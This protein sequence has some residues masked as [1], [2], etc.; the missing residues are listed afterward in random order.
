MSGDSFVAHLFLQ[1]LLSV[2][3]VMLLSLLIFKQVPE[4]QPQTVTSIARILD[5][6]G[7]T[8]STAI[9]PAQYSQ[10]WV[11]LHTKNE[12]HSEPVNLNWYVEFEMES[13]MDWLKPM[14]SIIP[15]IFVTHSSFSIELVFF[16]F[17]KNKKGKSQ[18][19]L[20]CFLLLI[21]VSVKR[22]GSKCVW[23]LLIWH[24][25]HPQVIGISVVYR[26]EKRMQS[27]KEK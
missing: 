1:K 7:V 10:I 25:V 27:L 26:V 21:A 22:I 15:V 6:V 11:T 17:Q 4:Q 20:S 14:W 16:F 2:G 5:P 9:V 3:S 19:A 23:S 24:S 8:T 12:R 18:F 13:K